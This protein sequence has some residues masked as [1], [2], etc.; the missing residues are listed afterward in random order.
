MRESAGAERLFKY[1]QQQQ[2]VKSDLNDALLKMH[3]RCCRQFKHA[4]DLDPDKLMKLDDDDKL[5]S[6]LVEHCAVL[7]VD[8]SSI[9]NLKK[10]MKGILRSDL[11]QL[12]TELTLMPRFTF[13]QVV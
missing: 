11:R 1:K 9:D 13:R 10:A 7:S 2:R 4:I 12:L 5:D 3:L 8:Q 6:A